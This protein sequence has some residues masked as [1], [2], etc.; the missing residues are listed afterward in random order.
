MNKQRHFNLLNNIKTGPL[1]A[2][3][4]STILDYTLR[5][6][7]N[8]YAACTIPASI[9]YYPALQENVPLCFLFHFT[10]G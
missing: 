6:C 4:L 8:V 2:L 10:T 9:L 1:R 7:H 3:Q 5:K